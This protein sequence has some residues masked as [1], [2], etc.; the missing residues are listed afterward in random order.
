M[1]QRLRIDRRPRSR[2]VTPRAR[3]PPTPSV[4]RLQVLGSLTY[5][6]SQ[7]AL[8][9]EFE[10]MGW[11][12]VGYGSDPID[13]AAAWKADQGYQFPLLCDPPQ[14]FAAKIGFTADYKGKSIVNRA[15]LIVGRDGV[16]SYTSKM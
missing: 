14:D 1:C 2:V 7:W 15:N 12:V 16:V 11:A 5:P 8:L 10:A 4:R 13:E 3:R 6:C 9:G